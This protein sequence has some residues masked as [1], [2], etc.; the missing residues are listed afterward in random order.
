MLPRSRS[1]PDPAEPAISAHQSNASS[2]DCQKWRRRYPPNISEKRADRSCFQHSTRTSLT[3]S[4][5]RSP[6]HGSKKK[7]SNA[8]SD[9]NHP[10]NVMG[11]F[12]CNNSACFKNGWGSKKIAILIRGYPGHDCNAIVFD[13]CCKSA[14]KNSQSFLPD[15]CIYRSWSP[16]TFLSNYSYEKLL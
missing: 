1:C 3:Q 7:D 8:G 5:T 15:L 6:R 16:S 4:P 2:L 9:N 11:K 10:T 12:K 13:Q 14:A